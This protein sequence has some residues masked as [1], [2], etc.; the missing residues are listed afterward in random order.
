M[1]HVDEHTLELLALRAPE[2]L[3]KEAAIRKHLAKCAGCRTTLEEIEGFYRDVERDYS[4][5]ASEV[6]PKRS[7]AL[8]RRKELAPYFD[9]IDSQGAVL[10]EVKV[11]S[12][13]RRARNYGFGHP[14]ISSSFA[15][16]LI[17]A[18]VLSLKAITGN[19]E[20]P[21]YYFYNTLTNHLEIYGGDNKLLWSL[22]TYNV[23][24][25]KYFEDRYG[26]HKTVI[27]DLYGNGKKEVVTV[28]ALRDH[29]YPQPIRVFDNR[30]RL[31]RSFTFK[32]KK[33]AFR[34]Q[35]Y[36]IPFQ[37][38]YIAPVK[39]PDGKTD[40]I[41]GATNTRSPYI[42]ARFDSRLRMI[43]EFWHYG[44]LKVN[45][46]DVYHDGVQEIAI[47]GWNDVHDTSTGSYNLVGVLD[48]SRI[49]GKKESVRTRG[50]GLPPSD[51]ELY[52]VRLP[53]SSIELAQALGADSRIL[54]EDSDSLLQ[55][56][57]EPLDYRNPVGFW[58]FDFIFSLGDMKVHQV[59]YWSTTP[60]TF[61]A[62]KKEGKVSGTFGDQYLVMLKYGVRYWNGNKWVKDATKIK[63]GV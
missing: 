19:A 3:G 56:E 55:V 10:A 23:A 26:V 50:F 52:Y 51:A 60:E 31:V 4:L 46:I 34:G 58:G 61:Q 27:A 48:P 22:P 57:V 6:K 20:N 16:I 13:W 33:I 59:K 9:A 39:A 7:T 49:T 43:G 1:K 38:D 18:L 32:D 11:P 41:V 47:T 2:V 15:A 42:I 53:K 35:Q 45:K 5:S 8:T 28:V 29:V 24:G 14:V 37:P 17:V 30:G 40:L 25:D 62:L 54:S 12:L 44:V 63:T 21:S 36:D